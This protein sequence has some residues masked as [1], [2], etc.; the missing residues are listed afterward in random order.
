MHAYSPFQICGTWLVFQALFS[1][2][3]LIVSIESEELAGVLISNSES[4][5]LVELGVV[6]SNSESEELLGLRVVVTNTGKRF[7]NH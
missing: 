4:E 2:M 7:E 6:V 5:K 1:H 3:Y